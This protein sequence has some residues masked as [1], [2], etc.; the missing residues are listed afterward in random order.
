MKW[1]MT[2]WLL[3]FLLNTRYVYDLVGFALFDMLTDTEQIEPVNPQD[4]WEFTDLWF[5]RQ[6]NIVV[7]IK[8]RSN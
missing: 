1:R 6:S 2:R 5:V 8:E 3:L 4:T 7:T